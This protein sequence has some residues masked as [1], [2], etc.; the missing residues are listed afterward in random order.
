MPQSS[1]TEQ[2]M[3]FF[4]LYLDHIVLGI[5]GFMSFIMIALV[6]ER[7]IYFFSVKLEKFDH[8]ELL[9]TALTRNLTT[10]S[11]VAANAPYVGLLGTVI[12]ILVTF[13]DMGQNENINVNQIMVGLALALKATAAGL[14]VAI[15]AIVFYNGLMRRVDTKVAQW[16]AL[17]DKKLTNQS[18]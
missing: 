1:N 18:K 5:L 7:S 4:R 11:T 9:K 2:M 14:V 8:I 6:I 12:G 3:N 17:S 13:Y 10:I 16:I 15:P